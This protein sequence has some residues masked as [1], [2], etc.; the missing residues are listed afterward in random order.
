MLMYNWRVPYIRYDSG[1]G[2]D[3]R[4]ILPGDSRVTNRRDFNVGFNEEK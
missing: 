1:T 4:S 3:A 2:R